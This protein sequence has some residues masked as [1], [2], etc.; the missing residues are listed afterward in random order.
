MSSQHLTPLRVIQLTYPSPHAGRHH[1]RY[2]IFPHAGPL[3][4]RTIRTARNFNH[5]FTLR[6]YPSSSSSSTRASN[7][8]LFSSITLHGS[9]ALILDA[10]KRGEDDED[11]SRG[12]LPV[13]KGRSIVVRVYES[14]GGQARGVLK[15]SLGVK[16]CWKTNILE[17]DE[18]EL[19]W[20]ARDGGEVGIQLRA[21][22]VATFRFQL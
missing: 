18:E 22:E 12:E 16:K 11:V 19:N 2:A 7:T 14:L 10:I 1:I 15:C 13:R 4:S 21:F 9:P 5:P 8:S 3:D 20:G 17:D 6:P